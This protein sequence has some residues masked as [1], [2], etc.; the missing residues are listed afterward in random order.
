MQQGSN[1]ADS[2]MMTNQMSRS[3][4]P[5]GVTEPNQPSDSLLPE[6][7]DQLLTFTKQ[8]AK[9]RWRSRRHRNKSIPDALKITAST[10]SASQLTQSTSGP[11]TM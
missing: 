8:R 10:M 9:T 2:I 6:S 7:S 3:S 5:I 1:L 4:E 11:R